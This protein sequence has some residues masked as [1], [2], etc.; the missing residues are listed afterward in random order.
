MFEEILGEYPS[1]HEA[2]KEVKCSDIDVTEAGWYATAF[3][4]VNLITNQWVHRTGDRK[5]AI[6]EVNR[7]FVGYSNVFSS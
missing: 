1:V 4:Y 5:A 6:K 3:C 7:N 2:M